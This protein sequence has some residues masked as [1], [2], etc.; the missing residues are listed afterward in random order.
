MGQSLPLAVGH[1]LIDS[2]PMD[3]HSTPTSHHIIEAIDGCRKRKARP[4]SERILKWINRKYS[5]TKEDILKALNASVED[6]SVIK[7]RYKDGISYRNPAKFTRNS[8]HNYVATMRQHQAIVARSKAAQVIKV[9]SNVSSDAGYEEEVNE[10]NNSD[11]ESGESSSISEEAISPIKESD[12]VAR[13]GLDQILLNL[14]PSL[15]E[16]ALEFP[17]IRSKPDHW[18]PQDVECFIRLIGFPEQAASF[19]EQE[20]DGIALLLLT[21]VDVLNGM[22]LK[23]GPALK[24]YGQI[25][26]LQTIHNQ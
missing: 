16:A 15:D 7:V 21:R 24:I 2:G 1:L 5:F 25:E 10:D 12:A 11:G 26:R 6:G 14:Q 9:G 23:L 4:D 13:E 20:I 3:S 19:R 8:A 22:S 17:G 18:T